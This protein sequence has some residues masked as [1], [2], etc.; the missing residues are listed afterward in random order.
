MVACERD[1]ASKERRTALTPEV[2]RCVCV[3]V[4][5][6]PH[7]CCI[8]IDRCGACL[9]VLEPASNGGGQF[10]PGDVGQLLWC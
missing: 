9:S 8:G 4:C 7:V 6:G 2:G 10:V 5:A 3:C 1:G